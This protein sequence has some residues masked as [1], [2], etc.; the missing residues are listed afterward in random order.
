MSENAEIEF[1]DLTLEGRISAVDARTGDQPDRITHPHQLLD[2]KGNKIF[3]VI[4]PFGKEDNIGTCF[5]IDWMVGEVRDHRGIM[6]MADVELTFDNGEK[7]ICFSDDEP[8][9]GISLKD[10]NIV[11]NS[12]NNHA[13]FTTLEAAEAYVMYRKMIFAEDES[14]AELEGDYAAHFTKDDVARLLKAEKSE[15]SSDSSE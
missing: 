1:S 12:Y 13:A 15:E 10:F 6:V 3:I 7:Y 14:I 2:M 4:S 8:E 5:M 9:N 11:P